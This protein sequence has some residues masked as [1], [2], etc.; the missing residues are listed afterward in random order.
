[1]AKITPKQEKFAHLFVELGNAAEAYRQAYNSKSNPDVVKSKAYEVG[2][3]PVVAEKIASLRAELSKRSANTLDTLIQELEDARKAAL[4]AETP[5]ASAAVG[6]TMG[7]AKLL[8]LDKQLV[9]HSG[10]VGVAHSVVL[11]QS[12]QRMIDRM[13]DDEC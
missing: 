3:S 8:G 13:L 5:Q 9:E 4:G 11:T 12:Q 2:K 10:S 6:A 1:M 7:K